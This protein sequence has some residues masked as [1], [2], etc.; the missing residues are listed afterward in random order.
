VFC[1][2]LF[3]YNGVLVDDEHVHLAAFQ[4][5]LDPLGIH[6]DEQTYWAHYLGFDDP[7]CF[8]A[9][10]E[11]HGRPIDDARVAELVAAKKPCYLRRAKDVLKGFPGAAELLRARALVGPV[12]IV[13]GALEEEI[14]LGLQVLQSS[15]Y[16]KKIISSEHTARSKPDPEGYELGLDHLRSLGVASPLTETIVFEDSLDGIRAAKAAGLCCIGIAHSYPQAQ[17][18]A[19]GADAVVEK[20]AQIDEELLLKVYNETRK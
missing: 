11:R 3:D 20:I 10:F 13:S 17:L 18:S 8:R 16:V 15:A 1:A 7:N 2:T 6:L 5:V 12:V 4:D 19:A 14:V 9:A